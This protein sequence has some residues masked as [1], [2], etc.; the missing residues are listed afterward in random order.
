[1]KIILAL[2]TLWKGLKMGSSG[3]PKSY[4]GNYCVRYWYTAL[5]KQRPAG[6]NVYRDIYRAVCSML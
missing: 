5:N 6:E 4:L 2:R 1:M 3:M